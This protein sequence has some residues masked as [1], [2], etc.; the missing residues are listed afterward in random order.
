[1][2]PE[3]GAIL[4]RTELSREALQ[5]HPIKPET[6]ALLTTYKRRGNN[7]AIQSLRNT[8]EIEGSGRT[9]AADVATLF[10]E[11][12]EMTEQ[13]VK[14][15][16]RELRTFLWLFKRDKRGA[17]SEGISSLNSSNCHDA[18]G[19]FVAR[20]NLLGDEVDPATG[21][22]KPFQVTIMRLRKTFASDVAV[23]RR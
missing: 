15:A 9:I 4:R 17:Y 18:I 5:P 1:M 13:F 20:N 2:P 10:Y 19:R 7:I 8:Q 3:Q 22:A 14:D 11:V 16:P 6:H 21:N 23:D 12:R